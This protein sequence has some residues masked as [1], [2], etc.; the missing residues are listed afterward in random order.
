S[1]GIVFWMMGMD[2]RPA[3]VLVLVLLALAARAH[4]RYRQFSFTVWVFVA[5][6]AAMFYPQYLGEIAGRNTQSLV[7][8]C[9]Q[10]IM[11]T[12][13]TTLKLE[14]FKR[15][16]VQP[17]GVLIGVAAQFLIMPLVALALTTAMGFPPEVAAGVIL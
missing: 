5:V 11:F 13:G 15:V 8:P 17:K 9:V 4:E 10:L 1:G 14:D 16:F 2:A 7:V 3:A 12:M 6:A